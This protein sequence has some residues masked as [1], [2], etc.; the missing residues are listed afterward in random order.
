M[1]RCSCYCY[2][3]GVKKGGHDFVFTDNNNYYIYTD[4]K[5]GDFYVHYGLPI[6]GNENV[7]EKLS[8]GIDNGTIRDTRSLHSVIEGMRSK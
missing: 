8:K 3:H 6:E 5:N 7:I 2:E 1:L 4:K